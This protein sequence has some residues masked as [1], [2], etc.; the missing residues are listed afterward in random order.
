MK[1][2]IAIVILSCWAVSGVIA[3]AT[4]ERAG[5]GSAASRSITDVPTALA[6]LQNKLLRKLFTRE[7]VGSRLCSSDPQL[8]A[9]CTGWKD[10][11]LGI[12]QALGDS[13]PAEKEERDLRF[14][15]DML[16]NAYG[17]NPAEQA[18]LIEALMS[19]PLRSIGEYAMAKQE[20]SRLKSEPWPLRFTAL[21]GSEVDLSDWRGKP[22]IVAFWSTNCVG[23][24]RQ[25]PKLKSLYARYHELGLQMVGVTGNKDP[26]R[27]A[28]FLETHDMT[29]PQRADSEQASADFDRFGFRWASNLLLFDRNGLLVRSEPSPAIADWEKLI[30][31][32]LG[33]P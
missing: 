29:W 10:E 9:L 23:C 24:R 21:D 33:L 4:Q 27:L 31:A 28:A 1:A 22:V 13:V 15:A 5:P 2:R 8:Q 32:E 11:L 12:F 3:D 6:A 26:A 18:A 20:L 19:V 25:I 17:D 7:G 30:R 14:L 16:H